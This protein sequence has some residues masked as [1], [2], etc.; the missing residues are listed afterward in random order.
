[1]Y[2]SSIFT[3]FLTARAITAASI[4]PRQ[5]LER[6]AKSALLGSDAAERIVTPDAEKYTDARL[7]E[8]IQ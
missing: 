5:S 1:M 3:F 4:S 6:C 8:K 7:G 2:Y